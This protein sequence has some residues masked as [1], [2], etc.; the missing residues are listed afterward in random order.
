MPAPTV[1]SISVQATNAQMKR[2]SL[3]GF[4]GWIRFM[5]MYAV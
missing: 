1:A 2:V 3:F 4:E 5:A